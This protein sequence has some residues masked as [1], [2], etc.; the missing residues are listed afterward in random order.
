METKEPVTGAIIDSSM[1]REEALVGPFEISPPH[2]VLDVQEL[3]DVYYQSFDGS[4]HKGQIVVNREVA[5]DVAGLFE[6]IRSIGFPIKSVIPI[7]DLR[8]MNDDDRSAYANNSS[9][10]N[11]RMIAKTD[12]LSNHSFGRAIDLNPY[13]N[14]YIREDYS[15]PEGVEYDPQLP[16]AITSDGPIVEFLKS[17]GWEWGGDWADRKDYMHFE[18]PQV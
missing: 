12:R 18:K 17:R 8:F 6:L 1:T 11:Y 4:L 16:G 10:F 7:G 3:V 5:D 2:E 9:G 15:Q 14:P 13:I